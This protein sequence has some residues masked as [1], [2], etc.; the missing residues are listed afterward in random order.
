MKKIGLVGYFGWGN[1][2]DELFV[3]AHKQHLGSTVK[4]E[5]VHDILEEPYF[6]RDLSEVVKNY[7]GLLIGGGD[8]LNPV[9]IS[10][11]YWRK[12]YLEK[13]VFITGLGVPNLKWSRQDILQRYRA[14]FQHKNVKMVIARDPES[15]KWIN[16]HIQPNV[17]AKFFPDPVC[18]LR[19]PEV[20]Q[21][22]EKL[23]G[24]V[25]RSHRSLTGDLSH[26]RKLIGV[27]LS[28]GYKIRHIVLGTKSI[29]E[30]DY[31]I[32]KSF[33]IPGEEIVYTESL[34][35]QCRAIGECHALA[36]IKFHG[37]IVATMYGIPTIALSSTPKNKNFLRMI[38][39]LDLSSGYNQEDLHTRMFHYP[40]RIHQIVRAHLYK[41]ST[42]GYRELREAIKLELSL[43]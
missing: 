27:A 39:R 18:S 13:P 28:Q 34:E 30:A 9:R 11:L 16:E 32:T 15:T 2:G 19:R 23:L 42:A 35:D 7:D 1:F 21:S 43:S 38:D 26:L 17:E 6:S 41:Q 8:L 20:E 25:I 37:L 22:K 40:A 14:F 31:E 24:V 5:P 10:T 29:G 33:A 3:E 4:L 12:E 36:S